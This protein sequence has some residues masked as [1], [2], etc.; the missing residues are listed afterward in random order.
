MSVKEL[1]NNPSALPFSK[2]KQEA[3]LGHLLKDLQFFMLCKDRI[4]PEWFNQDAVN[5]K[6]WSALLNFWTEYQRY[7]DNELE[8]L[9][10]SDI[11]CQDQLTK[12]RLT[13]QYGICINESRF[14]GLDT[15]K[16]LL[17]EWLQTQIYVKAM[18]KSSVQFNK[19]DVSEAFK[20]MREG[21]K[22]LNDAKFSPDEAIDFKNWQQWAKEDAAEMENSLTFGID[23]MDKLLTPGA[24]GGGLL[25]GDTTVILAPTNQGKTT[26]MVTVACANIKKGKDIL[27]LTHEGSS[28]D[29]RSKMLRCM[30]GTNGMTQPEYTRLCATSQGR[31]LI[32]EIVKTIDR[33]LVWIPMTKPGLTVEEVDST[34]VRKTDEWTQEHGKGF[35]MLVD[36][37]P[38][39][40]F[41]EKNSKG[42]LQKRHSDDIIYSYFVRFALA[43]KFH[44]L[45]AI[46][47]NRESAKVSKKM[48]GTED[49]L[50]GME[51]VAEAYGPMQT[52]TNV[53]TLNRSQNNKVIFNLCKSRSSE[54]GFAVACSSNY[55][56]VKTHSNELGGFAYR[57]FGTMSDR[58]DDYLMQYRNQIIPD[59]INSGNKKE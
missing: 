37:Y 39:L 1:M 24:S 18:S 10:F 32:N 31:D 29:L 28:R 56:R 43:F 55:G 59:Y 8:F 42:N 57:G 50:L 46:Q 2:K 38:A 54:T 20:L 21:I 48:K 13:Q 4:K 45:V 30:L 34:V 22:E 14:H 3:V 58:I 19:G 33:H 17:E 25:R 9:E 7:P 36:D 27:F 35:D 40:L 23:L 51:D 26:S 16:P 6:L 52:A 47:G 41:T 44:S 11:S 49:R 12:N 5:Q 15:I 53:I